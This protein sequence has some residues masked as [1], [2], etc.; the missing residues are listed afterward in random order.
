MKKISQFFLILS[1]TTL[2]QAQHLEPYDFPV[3]CVT[4]LAFY[5]SSL[6]AGTDQD[7]LYIRQQSD[8]GWT[9]FGLEGIHILSVYPHEIGPFGWGI[10]V[11]AQSPGPSG[12]ATV[13]FC[14]WSYQ[15]VWV[16][17]DSGLDRNRIWRI[18]SIDGFP[19]PRI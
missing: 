4:A 3:G 7:G 6:F 17:A 16:P 10:T 13:I 18:F 8:S 12:D 11:G 2:L 15:P 14:W 19:D 1:F 5:G 9:Y